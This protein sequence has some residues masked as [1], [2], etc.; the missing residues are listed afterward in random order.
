LAKPQISLVNEKSGKRFMLSYSA[1]TLPHFV[2]W[3]SMASGDYALGFEPSTT[4]LDD[5]FQYRKI[6]PG[7]KIRFSLELTVNNLIEG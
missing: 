6:A 3:K 5:R 1:D 7:E 2:E 4:E